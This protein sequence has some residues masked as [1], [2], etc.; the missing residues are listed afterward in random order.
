MAVVRWVGRQAMPA[1]GEDGP[2]RFAADALSP[3]IP[4]RDVRLSP[5]HAVFIDGVLVPAHRLANGATIRREYQSET[6]TYLH[7]ELDRHDILLAEGL[8][9]ESY[10]DTGNRGQF[11]AECGVRPVLVVP[12]ADPVQAALAAYRERGCAPLH[13]NGA[14]A[15][16]A[17]ARLF[18]R[19]QDMGWYLTDNPSV[20]VTSDMPNV[21]LL[22]SHGPGDLLFR[23]PAGASQ[24]HLHS[25][26]FFPTE[27]DAGIRDGRRLGVALASVTLDGVPLPED[28]YCAG[29]YPPESGW[30]WT[31]GEACLRVARSR[32]TAKLRLKI[33]DMKARYWVR[34]AEPRVAEDRLQILRSGLI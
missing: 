15:D 28:A 13:L 22:A 5:D 8:P 7:V 16:A 3:G 1:G 31:D 18:Q 32:R 33:A 9:A 10:L 4:V 12:A 20:T 27:M 34:L 11:A 25:R 6:L 2:V 24:V 30:R 21:R 29:F 17:H 14:S 23:I 26:S 19:A